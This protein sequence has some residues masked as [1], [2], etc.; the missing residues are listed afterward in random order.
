MTD[1]PQGVASTITTS[2]TSG[3]ATAAATAEKVVE[4]IAKV[5]GPILTGVSIF[6]PGAAAIT[7]P[8]ETI[9]PLVIPDIEKALNDIASGTYGDL[10]TVCKEFVDHI[11]TGAPNSPILS[12]AAAVI[13]AGSPK[14]DMP[15]APS[16]S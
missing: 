14:P 12:K 16:G 8:L 9:L 10:W 3:I 13:A 6:V 7:V 4:A 11:K 5:E 2:G 1:T 15:P